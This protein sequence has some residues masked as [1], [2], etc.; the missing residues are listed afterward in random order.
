MEHRHSFELALPGLAVGAVAG[1]AAGGLTLIAGQP[2][3]T[4]A[5]S[6]LLLATPLGLLGGGYGLLMSRGTIRPGL[7]APAGLYWLA[8]F[9]L[10]RLVQETALGLVLAGEVVLAGGLPGFLAYQ[11][12]V[13]LGFALGFVW[14]HE[15]L[16]PYWLLRVRGRNPRARELLGRYVAH[17]EVL[18]RTAERRRAPRKGAR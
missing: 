8:G 4:A 15:R 7:F 17:A 14:L 10:A 6:A 1:A 2:A 5:L 11:A 18:R 3:G 12:M 13:S 16:M 9:P